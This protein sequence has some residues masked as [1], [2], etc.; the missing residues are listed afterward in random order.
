MIL[1]TNNPGTY[2]IKDLYRETIRSFDE[3][4]VLLSKL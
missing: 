4:K 3:K 1:L 2:K